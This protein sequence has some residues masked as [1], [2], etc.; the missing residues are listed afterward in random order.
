MNMRPLRI[1]SYTIFFLGVIIGL[2]LAAVTI[3]NKTEAISYF[4]RGAKH[5][6]FHGLRCPVFL[7]PPKTG[8]VTLVFT[9][10]TEEEDTFFS[11]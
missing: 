4:F 3:W 2:A 7:A 11:R 1:L 6:P 9:T 10:P 8:T 5:D